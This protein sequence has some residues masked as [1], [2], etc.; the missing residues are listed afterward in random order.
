[1]K[2]KLLKFTG[3]IMTKECMEKLTLTEHTEYKKGTSMLE[4]ILEQVVEILE[5]GET[6]L[7]APMDRN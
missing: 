5:R 4:C 1:M 7:S 3:N 2:K 6:L